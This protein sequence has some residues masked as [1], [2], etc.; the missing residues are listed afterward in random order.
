MPAS[1]RCAKGAGPINSSDCA[2]PRFAVFASA[3][4]PV[5]PLALFCYEGRP[6]IAMSDDSE[7]RAAG[8]AT[9]HPL[10]LNLL[11][12]FQHHKET[13]GC[14]DTTHFRTMVNK[15]T[16]E[17]LGVWHG[18]SYESPCAQY[19]APATVQQ[20]K[21]FDF[22]WADDESDEEHSMES[23]ESESSD[24]EEA[25]TSASCDISEVDY[26]ENDLRRVHRVDGSNQGSHREHHDRYHPYAYTHT[27]S[28][29]D[30]DPFDFD[31]TDF[32]FFGPSD[33]SLINSFSL[34]LATM[35]VPGID[36][37]AFDEFTMPYGPEQLP[38]IGL[39]EDEKA[40][41]VRKNQLWSLFSGV[42]D[43]GEQGDNQSEGVG[44]RHT[45]SNTVAT[46]AKGHSNH[47]A[48]SNTKLGGM[49]KGESTRTKTKVARTAVNTEESSVRRPDRSRVPTDKEK[50]A[51]PVA[52][53][54]A[55]SARLPIRSAL[56]KRQGRKKRNRVT[57]AES[58]DIF[59][60]EKEAEDQSMDDDT[61]A[62]SGRTVITVTVSVKSEHDEP[63]L[64]SINTPT[65]H[66]Q[67]DHGAGDAMVLDRDMATSSADSPTFPS[68]VG[69]I[70]SSIKQDRVAHV[71]ASQVDANAPQGHGET[72]QSSSPF[73]SAVT[74][75]PTTV[76]MDAEGRRAFIDRIYSLYQQE[77]APFH[78]SE[79]HP[80]SQLTWGAS[81]GTYAQGPPAPLFLTP[82][83]SCGSGQLNP[84]PAIPFPPLFRLP[85][86]SQ[87]PPTLEQAPA[88]RRPRPGKP[89]PEL[90]R[91]LSVSL[92][93]F[94][95]RMKS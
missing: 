36:L 89:Y 17:V 13:C 32:S 53:R 58:D 18:P 76:C 31:P 77:P 68:L 44:E 66:V 10:P 7:Q 1:R 25:A 65:P 86:Q 54:A 56:R 85:P 37:F 19:T 47:P 26:V 62:H 79:G 90:D 93:A 88:V 11:D 20:S 35:Q 6:T 94:L 42:D 50:W 92:T 34:S 40:D 57:W 70:Y 48:K 28:E 95:G 27:Q 84:R 78:F 71:V 91:N 83:P 23:S 30:I 38:T 45:S 51:F 41:A 9:P 80:A 16:R 12:A 39:S 75:P 64:S 4:H 61:Q 43:N 87:V 22:G 49:K 81:Q 74:R 33:L 15:G 2:P 55:R 82:Q 73:A 21:C 60:F 59:E 46:K 14:G 5:R 52:S 67:E 72:N 3:P 8:F 24:D 69:P 63:D 29:T